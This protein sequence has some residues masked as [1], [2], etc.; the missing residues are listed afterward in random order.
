MPRTTTWNIFFNFSGQLKHDAEIYIDICYLDHKMVVHGP[1]VIA[2]AA[3]EYTLR[4]GTRGAIALYK[5]ATVLNI[6]FVSE[7][8]KVRK[9]AQRVLSLECI[10]HAYTCLCLV[11]HTPCVCTPSP[12]LATAL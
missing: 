3:V 2:A 9:K 10:T 12:P 8:V 4:T 11:D 6:D 5:E 1:E 7:P